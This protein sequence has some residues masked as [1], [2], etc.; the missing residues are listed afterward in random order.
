MSENI[1][2]KN[3]VADALK[4]I[5]LEKAYLERLKAYCDQVYLNNY[6]NENFSYEIESALDKIWKSQQKIY[7]LERFVNK[8]QNR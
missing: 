8:L 4:D 2:I 1:N 5:E 6:K 3:R 7:F